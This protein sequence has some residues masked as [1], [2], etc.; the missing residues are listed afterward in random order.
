MSSTSL[1]NHSQPCLEFGNDSFVDRLPIL[2]V[3]G[4]TLARIS[5]S[6]KI[7]DLVR[8]L[9]DLCEFANCDE[10]VWRGVKHTKK[11]GTR[12]FET[13]ELEQRPTQCDPCRQVRGMLCEAHLAHPNGLFER[14]EEHTSEL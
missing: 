3:A 2:A 6:P 11:L 1:R 5:G 8:S 14:S 10:V 9:M 13:I 7:G 12:V 4:C